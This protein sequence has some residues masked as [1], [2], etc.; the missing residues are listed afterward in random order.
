MNKELKSVSN[1]NLLEAVDLSR[2]LLVLLEDE[3]GRGLW[4][5]AHR[6]YQ[7]LS[8]EYSARTNASRAIDPQPLTIS[9]VIKG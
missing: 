7:N 1:H 4:W 9:G 8:D 2:K 6:M 5:N 3:K